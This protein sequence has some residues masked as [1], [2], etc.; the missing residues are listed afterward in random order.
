MRNWF[1]TGTSRGLGLAIAQ[2]AVGA[3]EHVTATGR[4]PEA[5]RSR[6]AGVSRSTSATRMCVVSASRRVARLP[7]ASQ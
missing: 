7:H 2:A 1:I 5:V 4:D 6:I 3:G